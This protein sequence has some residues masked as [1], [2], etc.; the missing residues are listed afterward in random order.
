MGAFLR[1]VPTNRMLADG[2]TKN[3]GDPVDLLRACIR[4]SSYQISPEETV[5]EY[6]ALEKELR[7]QAKVMPDPP[8]PSTP[9][10][11]SE[12]KGE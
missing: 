9:F 8:T 6:K 12:R 3:E 4:R 2:L 1:W 7:K 5:L 10:E 11:E